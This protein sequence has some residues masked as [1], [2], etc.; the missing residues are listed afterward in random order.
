MEAGIR[1]Q[2]LQPPLTRR[3]FI[4][5]LIPF[6]F[7]QIVESSSSFAALFDNGC[8]VD[9]EC[10]R[11]YIFTANKIERLSRFFPQERRSLI[12]VDD[13]DMEQ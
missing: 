12:C 4:I 9:D 10:F 11:L 13:N 5:F 1:T 2:G 7:H 8:D 3:I 6:L